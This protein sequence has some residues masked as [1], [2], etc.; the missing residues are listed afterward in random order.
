MK[1]KRGVTKK[2]K[3]RGKK[4]KAHV[5]VPRLPAQSKDFEPGG[6]EYGGGG[7]SGGW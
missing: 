1:T 3:G 4:R 7:A 5:P 6:G 2:R